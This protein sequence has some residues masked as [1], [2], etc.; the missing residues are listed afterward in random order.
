MVYRI[1]VEKKPERANEAAALQKDAKTVL[2]IG[3]LEDVRVINRYDVENIDQTLFEDCRYKVFAEPQ[4]DITSDTI[5]ANGAACVFAVEALPGQFDQ[6]A[7]SA[8][9][10]IQIISQ[11]ERPRVKFAR[12]FILYGDLSGRD[13]EAVKRHVINPVEAREASLDMPE[14]LQMQY[15]IPE[16]VETLLGFTYMGD[17]RLS[18]YIKDMGLAM[19]EADLAMCRDYFRDV[20]QRNPTVTELRMIDTYWSDHCRHTT[21]GTVIDDV[22]FEDEVLANAFD[23]YIKTRELLGRTDKCA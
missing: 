16:T 1:Y 23:D 8:E 9:Q 17:D 13:I 2:G 20:E 22:H 18:A 3:G 10:C 6:R 19:D 14:T 15:E 11:G 7:D 5:D 4:L 21:F 12:V